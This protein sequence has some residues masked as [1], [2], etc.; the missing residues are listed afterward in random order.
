MNYK[1]KDKAFTLVK[2][3]IVGEALDS[4]FEQNDGVVLPSTVV[5]SATPKRSP[6]HNCFEWD[7]NAA[8]KKYRESQASYLLRSIVIV[9]ESADEDTEPIEVRAFVSVESDGGRFYTT[10]GRAMDDD[11]M[12]CDIERQAYDDYMALYHKYKDLKLFR[13]VN[14]EIDKVKI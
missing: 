13:K 4:I 8:A 9:R 7:D 11:E 2:A 6:I 12:F 1:Y 3:Q 10:I 14:K 5:R